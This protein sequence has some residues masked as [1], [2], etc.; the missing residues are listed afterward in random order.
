MLRET[1][2]ITD[3]KSLYDAVQKEAKIREPRVAL[4]VAEINQSMAIV[5]AGVRWIPHNI[6]LADGLTK[7]LTKANLGPLMKVMSRGTYQMRSEVD[8]RLYREQ[9]K[10]DGLKVARIKGRRDRDQI[11]QEAAEMN[12]ESLAAWC[13]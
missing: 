5:S 12:Q 3:A 8:E 4:A 13:S 7:K 9:V 10:D 1:L 6:M 2:G 11:N